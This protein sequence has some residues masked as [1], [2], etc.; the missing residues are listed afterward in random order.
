MGHRALT[1]GQGDDP[2]KARRSAYWQAVRE[3]RESGA[4]AAKAAYVFPK[5]Q[6]PAEVRRAVLEA[7]DYLANPGKVRRRYRGSKSARIAVQALLAAWQPGRRGRPPS[8]P[9]RSE[10]HDELLGLAVLC[11]QGAM[12][13]DDAVTQIIYLLGGMSM[14]MDPRT[15][16]ARLVRML[17]L[18]Q[19]VIDAK[20]LGGPT[21]D[22]ANI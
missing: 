19:Q 3:A 12:T 11:L 17:P 13:E 22:D 10:H 9:E 5:P 16:K 21:A 4:R 14:R 15:A 7:L 6:S 18:A 1:A 20:A 2:G 8:R